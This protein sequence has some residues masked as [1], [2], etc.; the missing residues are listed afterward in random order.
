MNVMKES[1][2]GLGLKTMP[3]HWLLARLGKRVLRPGGVEL[4]RRM[5][6]ELDILPSDAVVEFA[7]GLGF[8]ARL[9]LNRR[10]YSYTAI[11]QEEAAAQTVSRILP[12]P[13]Q[14]CLVG[15]AE[16]TGLPGMSATVVYGEAMLT[17]QT[18]DLKCRILKEAYRLLKPGGRYGIHELVGIRRF[19][20]PSRGRC[21]HAPA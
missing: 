17:M 9:T 5:L 12:G 4:T 6:D 8:T 20:D 11:E 3:G 14:R 16:D 21:P 18:P 1:R 2:E 19:R 13:R 10:P 7:P 15:S